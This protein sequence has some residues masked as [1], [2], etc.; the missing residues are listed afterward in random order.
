MP[1]YLVTFHILPSF[2]FDFD[3]LRDIAWD[4]YFIFML[5]LKY[6]VILLSYLCK[7][8]CFELFVFHVKFRGNLDRAVLKNCKKKKEEMDKSDAVNCFF[9]RKWWNHNAIAFI[10]FWLETF[11]KAKTASHIIFFVWLFLTKETE[12]VLFFN[13]Y[14]WTSKKRWTK[15]RCPS[16]YLQLFWQKNPISATHLQ[17]QFD[18]ITHYSAQ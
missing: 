18:S 12:S 16:F 9:G 15:S 6:V 17:I 11:Q 8:A 13:I 1:W 2:Y 3:I 4:L 7:M 5:Y 10:T 14:F